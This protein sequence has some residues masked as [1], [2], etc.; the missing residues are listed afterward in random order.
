M[1]LREGFEKRIHV[2]TNR[3]REKHPQ[4]ICVWVDGE[5]MDA[6]EVEIL[7]PSRLVCDFDSPFG[8]LGASVWIETDAEVQ[9]S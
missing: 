9:V 2:D 4:P 3:V 6:S 8:Q 7:G 1:D 5:R